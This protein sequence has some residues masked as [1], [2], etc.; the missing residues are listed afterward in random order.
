M[1]EGL[2]G[3]SGLLSA[4]LAIDFEPSKMLLLGMALA[5]ALL[6]PHSQQLIDE[7]RAGSTSD[8]RIR[9]DW[10][11]TP[12]WSVVVASLLLLSL[13]RMANVPEFVYFQF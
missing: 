8:G 7:A 9:L 2:V 5:I 13:M 4:R 11:P 12:G 6:M 1:I 10:H 3:L